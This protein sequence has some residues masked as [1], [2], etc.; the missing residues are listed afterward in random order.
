MGSKTIKNKNR[1]TRI[2][3]F[4]I[5]VDILGMPIYHTLYFD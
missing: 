2:V 1:G 5:G 3:T 4:Q